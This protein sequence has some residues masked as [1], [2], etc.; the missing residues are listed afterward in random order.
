MGTIPDRRRSDWLV[1]IGLVLLSLVPASAG[2]G[3]LAQIAAG[4][5]TADNARFIAAPLPVVLHILAAIPFSLLGAFQF[6]SALR[7]R[8]RGW[9]RAAGRFI[10][11]FGMVVALS[12]LWM[13]VTYPGAALDAMAVYVL[14]L[15]FG[16]A[17]TGCIVLGVDALRHRDFGA[18]GRWM[19]RSYAI[20]MAAGTQV[21]THLPWILLVGSMGVTGRALMMGAGWVINVAIAEWVIRRHGHRPA[22]QVRAARALARPA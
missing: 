16:T 11:V 3:R 13:T 14:R 20:G 10:V 17:M 8:H 4:E 6:S 19:M 2:T 18:H 22:R 21:L 12:G 1:P 7:R 9:H 15:V 5:V